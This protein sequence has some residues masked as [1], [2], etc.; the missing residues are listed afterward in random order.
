MI[1]DLHVKYRPSTFDEVLGQDHV[2]TSLKALFKNNQHPH[3]YLFTGSSGTGK[4]TL[5]RIVASELQCNDSNIIELDAASHSGV[6]NIRELTQSL[7]YATFGTN[8]NKYIILDEVHTFSKSA[9]QA[10]LKTLEEP[11]AHV[12]FALC[13]TEADKV[14]DTIKTRCHTYNLKDVSYDDLLALLEFVAE[15]ESI[16]FSEQDKSL[17]SIAQAS[18]GSPRR[19]LT[20]LSK[21]RGCKDLASIKLILEEPNEDGEV[22]EL[23]RLLI[24]RV[25]PQWKNVIR[26]LASLEGQ[27]AESIRLII[28][29]YVSKVLL[30][31]RNDKDA[32]K[33]LGVL[34]AFSTPCNQ[35]EKFAPLLLSL[36]QIVFGEDND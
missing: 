33:L 15:E 12:Y 5:A 7:N 23:C 8:P 21:C 6:D 4:T 29:N 25:R 31:A 27:N 14:P 22:I 17:R 32:L 18:M 9:W 3:A 30:N 2:V 19:A 34:D 20:F 1:Q 24:G 26:I 10:L 35:S 16:Q 28:V 36:G 11:P 13:T